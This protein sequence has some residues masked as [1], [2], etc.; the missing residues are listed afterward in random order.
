M[1]STKRSRTHWTVPQSVRIWLWRSRSLQ[2]PKHS[3][4]FPC[5]THQSMPQSRLLIRPLRTHQCNHLKLAQ[6]AVLPLTAL[7]LAKP[8]Q[9]PATPALQS[10]AKLIPPDIVQG[11]ATQPASASQN[12]GRRA[13]RRIRAQMGY[14]ALQMGVAAT[15]RVPAPANPVRLGSVLQSQAP[16]TRAMRL[17]LAPARSVREAAREPPMASALGR[18]ARAARL[19]ARL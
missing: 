18:P 1:S 16:H 8:A 13:R 3:P 14:P 2:A 10:Q 6:V 11:H 17:V 19:A 7:V 12:K 9:P 5:Q 15:V 4:T